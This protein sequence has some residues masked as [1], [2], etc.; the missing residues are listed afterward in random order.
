MGVPAKSMPQPQGEKQANSHS[1]EKNLRL[2]AEQK[3]QY[4]DNSNSTCYLVPF[5]DGFY[6]EIRK[7]APEDLKRYKISCCNRIG[8]KLVIYQ[9]DFLIVGVKWDIPYYSN[10]TGK[11]EQFM[12][13]VFVHNKSQTVIQKLTLQEPGQLKKYVRATDRAISAATLNE[14]D[15]IEENVIK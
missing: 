1:H 2:F 6:S 4:S 5:D 8:L 3:L 10:E 7:L 14:K 12:F 15:N 9:D 11:L 13:S